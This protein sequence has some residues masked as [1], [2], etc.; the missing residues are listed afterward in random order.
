MTMLQMEV[1]GG[2][3]ARASVEVRSAIKLTAWHARWLEHGRH[4]VGCD[5]DKREGRVSRAGR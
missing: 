2:M 5:V 4:S 3:H 1:A